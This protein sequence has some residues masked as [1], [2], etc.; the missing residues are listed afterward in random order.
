VRLAAERLSAAL[1]DRYRLDRELGQ[2]GMATVYLAQDLK[3]GRKVALKV[4]KPELAAVLGADRFVVEITTTASLQHPHILPLF[5]SGTADGFLFYVMPFI[6]G[7]TLRDKLNRETQLGVD[8]AVRIARE[9]ADALDY[10]HG[11]GVIHRDIKPENI[12]I[13]NGRP[14]VADFGIALAVSAA[15][16]G[17]M[18]ETGLSLGTPHYMSPEQATADKD[19]TGRSDIY[20]LGSVLYE[21]LTGNPPHVGASAQQIIMKIIAD[22][23]RPVT[24]LRKSVPPNVAAAVAKA[25]EKLPADRFDSARTFSEA[26]GNTAFSLQSTDTAIAPL[27]GSAR[28]W[29]HATIA[30]GAVAILLGTALV[31]SVNRESARVAPDRD[32]IRFGLSD[33]ASLRVDGSF[34]HPLAVS[35]D[36]RSVVFRGATDTTTMQLWIRSLDSPNAR[37]LAGTEGGANAAFSSDG[38]WLAFI[39]DLRVVKKMPS[40]GGDVTTVTAIEGLT[41]GLAWSADTLILIEQIGNDDGMQRVNAAGGRA[42]L[43][44][45]KDTVAREI[46]QRRPIIL[47][48]TDVV[49]YGSTVASSDE[50]TLV[51]YRLTDGKRLRT[52]LPGHGALGMIDDR[53]V[54]AQSDGSLMAVEIDARSMRVRGEPFRLTTRVAYGTPGTAVALSRSGVLV[55]RPAGAAA[56]ARLDLVDMAG[57]ARTVHPVAAFVGAPR[58][59]RD[60]GKVAVG[61]AVD[62]G[63]ARGFRVTTSDLWTI[64]LAT[65]E[66]TR[67]TSNN[68]VAQPSWFPDGQRLLYVK[69]IAGGFELVSHRLDGS[70][71]PS[72]LLTVDDVPYA[73]DVA[74]DG[75]TLVV[76]TGNRQ[77]TVT[78]A[79]L[80]LSLGAETQV[81]TLIAA[82]ARLRPEYARISP[83]GQWICFID[84][85]SYEVWVRSLRDS[86]TMMVSTTVSLDSPPVWGPDSRTLYYRSAAGMSVI[87]LNTSPGLSVARRSAVR[88]LPT[89]GAFDLSPDGKAF[90]ILTPAQRSG[91]AVIAVDW[92]NEARREW[93]RSPGK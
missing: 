64:D 61:I 48:G 45:P 56:L 1:A 65:G 2:G 58:F 33:D 88:G 53:L 78:G 39:T 52:G 42:E 4:L 29:K 14:M 81:D 87:E 67:V 11:K 37:P 21:M 50:A 20:S 69:A 89:L 90:V 73:A 55:Y 19:L 6:E 25:I 30:T 59:S 8:E 26:L 34:T 27:G 10:A 91:G 24:E 80:R 62:G 93:K 84:R 92:A 22:T 18:T 71:P 7:E 36:G 23:P 68:A 16:G 49:V 85:S 5:D 54:Y 51:L 3:H 76:R 12:L 60:G 31:A 79:L 47:P 83:D 70:A 41:A 46:R 86:S 77:T 74:A 72:R 9:V 35:P 63:V 15:A 13:Q 44:I 40:R 32:P 82:S 75:R 38:K 66:A 28:T 43:A 17:R 57:R